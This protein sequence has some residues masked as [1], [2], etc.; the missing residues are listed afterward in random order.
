MAPL[1]DGA[2][3]LLIMKGDRA[4]ELG[5]QPQFRILA[6]TSGAV[7][8]QQMGLAP[9]IAIAKALKKARL[10]L[11]KIQLFEINEIFAAHILVVFEAI[12]NPQKVDNGSYHEQ[13]KG[14]INPDIVNV[15]GGALAI[16]HS[17]A[18]S[19]ARIVIHLMKEMQR[20]NC[21]LGLATTAANGGQASALILER[22]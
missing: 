22:A 7:P 12:R 19:S 17:L 9:V 4:R 3:A 10:T 1:V 5:Y 8:P 20:R 2:A 16:G 21:N 11:D 6:H 18:G 14:E 15:N 13:L